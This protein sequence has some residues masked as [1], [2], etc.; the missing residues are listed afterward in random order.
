[1]IGNPHVCGGTL[2]SYDPAYILTAAHCVD[3]PEHPKSFGQGSSPYFV[4]Y[5][6]I[7]RK[8]Q[9]AIA[10]VDWDIHPLYNKT[11]EVDIR[12]DAAIVKLELPLRPSQRLQRTPFWSSAVAEQPPR[13]AELIGFGYTDLEGSLA[14]TLQMLPLDITKFDST[15]DDLVESRS[16]TE[17]HIACHGDSGGP[18]IVYYPTFNTEKNETQ[19]IQYVLGD[20]TRIFGARD[21]SPEA[22]TCPLAVHED[23][24]YGSH[25]NTVS[26]V[27]TNAISL[28]DWIANVTSIGIQ[29]LQ[30]PFYKPPYNEDEESSHAK[31]QEELQLHPPWQIGVVVDNNGLLD[32]KEAHHFWIGLIIYC[33]LL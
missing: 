4:L 14:Q 12:Y 10:I 7:H 27:F 15:G 2:I 22:L 31:D 18:L 30:D 9:K 16:K 20:L 3:A 32:T 19:E 5:D 33:I 6:D 11:G 1:M 29:D 13:Q 23:A 28:V 25:L 26:Q 24:H 8:E 17:P 21:A